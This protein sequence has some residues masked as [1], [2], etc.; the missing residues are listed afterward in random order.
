MICVN[1]ENFQ[2][3][4]AFSGL[5]ERPDDYHGGDDGQALQLGR[6]EA[7]GEEG[8]SLIRG[9]DRGQSLI[10]YFVNLLIR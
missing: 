5:L 6:Q 3:F 4:V 1:V 2:T 9:R 10:Y 8:R 7:K